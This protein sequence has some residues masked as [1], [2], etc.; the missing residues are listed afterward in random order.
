MI[1]LEKNLKIADCARIILL[2]HGW[3][4]FFIGYMPRLFRKPINSGIC[5][6]VLETVK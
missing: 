2:K 6:T 5:W 3:K 1:S 4:G